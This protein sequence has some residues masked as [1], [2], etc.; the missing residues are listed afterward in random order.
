MLKAQCFHTVS[1]PDD[2][3]SEVQELTQ[4]RR[5]IGLS[6]PFIIW[7]PVRHLCTPE[8]LDSCLKSAKEVDVFSPNHNEILRLF[9]YQP[10]FDR[11]KI[12]ELAEIFLDSGVGPAGKGFVVVRSG[13]NGCLVT[14]GPSTARVSVWVPSFY[15]SADYPAGE[16]PVIDPTGA[17]NAFLGGFAVGWAKSSDAIEA[18]VYGSIA[19][20]FALEQFGTPKL[21]KSDNGS[22]EVWNGVVPQDRLQKF[23]ARLEWGSAH[24]SGIASR[25]TGMHSE[26]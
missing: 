6:R 26:Q 20:S 2:I 23:Q 8:S 15:D 16:S 18:V 24:G 11:Q 21:E 4:L 3:P 22:N 7:E 19:S 1:P 12:Q 10:Q 5:A 13:A 25:T 17:G 14:W 9:N